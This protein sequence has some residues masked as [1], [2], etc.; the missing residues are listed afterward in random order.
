MKLF[1]KK[2]L[3]LLLALSMIM[4]VCV[5]AGEAKTL[6]V[7]QTAT[8]TAAAAPEGKTVIWESSDPAKVTVNNGTI[9]GIAVGSATIT[10]KY[11]SAE[12]T[13]G[14]EAQYTELDTWE[15]TV[16]KPTIKSVE[17][18]TIKVPLGLPGSKLA[19]YFPAS[20]KVTLGSGSTKTLT[21]GTD[22][23]LSVSGVN[24]E[25]AGTYPCSAK[26]TAAAE[27]T[28][29]LAEGVNFN[30]DI[31]VVTTWSLSNISV[32]DV[33]EDVDDPVSGI[34]SKIRYAVEQI[35]G[36]SIMSSSIDF[37]FSN[38]IKGEMYENEY[39]VKE[40]YQDDLVKDG[41][42]TDTVTYEAT[43][44][45]VKFTGQIGLTVYTTELSDTFTYAGDNLSD[46]K[47]AIST[48][49][50]A[51][52]G[53]TLSAVY[54]D[55]IELDGGMLYTDSTCEYEIDEDE[56]SASEFAALYYLPDGS[57]EP[58][59]I[60]YTAYDST[61]DYYLEGTISLY[62]DEFLLLTG[63]IT[64]EEVI[65]LDGATFEDAFLDLNS[66][67]EYLDYVTFTKPA[68]G[69][70]YL[71]VEYDEDDNKHTS[72]GTST[73]YYVEDDSKALID[74]VTYV[75]GKD[76]EGVVNIK[77]KAIGYND[78]EKKVTVDGIMQITVTVAADITI[79]AGKE[80]TV[81]I[82][83]DLFLEYIEDVDT[84][85][86]DLEIVSVAITNAPYQAKK[87]YLVTDGDELT[88]SGVKT[89]YA[90]EDDVDVSK[91]KYDLYDLSFLGGTAD[92]TVSG[93]FKVTYVRENSTKK[94]YADGTID[95]VTGASSTAGKEMTATIWASE[96]EW[97]G[98]QV[99]MDSF[100]ILGGNNNEYVVFTSLPVGGKLVYNWGKTGQ[101]DVTLG[102]KYYLTAKPG[103]QLMS[104]VTFV[105]SYSASKVQKTIPMEFKAY[106]AK[107]K[108]VSGKIILTVNHNPYSRKF[109]DITTNTYADSVDFLANQGITTGM[110][111]TT[112][113]PNN[114]VTRAQ[115]VTFL[116]RAAGSPAVTG[117]TNK[118]TDVKS[119][120]EYAYAYQAILWAVQ[121]NIT[122]G[123]SATSFAPAANVTHQELLTFLYRYDVNYLKHSATT[124]SYVNYT[125][126]SSVDSWAQTPVKWADYKGILDGY[127]IQPKVPGTRATVALWL[128]RML[129]L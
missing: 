10:A 39:Y 3:A 85:N 63:E 62:A 99:T 54:F 6:E 82:D 127:T 97:F 76:T 5:F 115:F 21:V 16:T 61:G 72:I 20:F 77:F 52:Y 29:A 53:K 60:Y 83:P 37:A 98:K 90:D 69:D 68:S 51:K 125:D 78:D 119:T 11:Q 96:P 109:Y 101:K 81:E 79:Q 28:Y 88:K 122:T 8:L 80:Q 47:T 43:Y 41:S 126:Y 13:E 84:S 17:K 89:F 110:T 124:S 32:T 74:D 73:K 114:N 42:L 22:V 105:P 25:T 70:G 36:D 24:T 91:K 111:A 44:N 58:S 75:P 106:N 94:Y 129:T 23:T 48:R 46:L 38:G 92:G 108:A 65:E 87:G 7:N 100:K 27:E 104:N 2:T 121:N 14:A 55:D 1:G 56:Y 26:L 128:H 71:Y 102:T 118:F 67:Y 30:F 107:D 18:Q 50:S 57:G 86:K 59:V 35:Y 9:K 15:V 49:L 66:D 120:G 123:R 93:T 12:A 112:F 64:S 95:F 19:S 31:Q 116:W 117:V 45:G 40:S 33:L 113:G 34:T 4:S 103:A